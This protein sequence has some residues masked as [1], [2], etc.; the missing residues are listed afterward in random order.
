MS[1]CPK[2]GWFRVLR[3]SFQSEDC[4]DETMREHGCESHMIVFLDLAEAYDRREPRDILWSVVTV[5]SV[6]RCTT[7]SL[8]IAM[9][10]ALRAKVFV[11]LEVDRVSKTIEPIVG[12]NHGDVLG[13]VLSLFIY[14]G[15]HD[16]VET[17][18]Q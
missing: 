18:A 17:E 4:Y 1:F 10:K 2:L 13:P 15:G 8:L 9:L 14:G 16:F 6:I 3:W 7:Q 11:E 12:V 5:V